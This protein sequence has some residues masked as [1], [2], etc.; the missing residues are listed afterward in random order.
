MDCR[1]IIYNRKS[2]RDFSGTQI[3]DQIITEMIEAARLAP[4]FQNKQCWRFV[5]IKKKEM[6]SRLADHSGLVGKA[7]FF[8][9]KAPLVV[10]A[11]ADPK[12]SGSMNGMDYY[13]VDTSIAFHQMMLLAQSYGIG[14]CWLA[15]FNEKK[16]K[17]VLDI[18]DNIKVVAM[19]PFGYPAEK[20]KLYTK[21]VKIFS[22]SK[23]RLSVSEIACFDNWNL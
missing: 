13:L 5:I 19:S 15:A 11:C 12:R 3:S 14:S 4:S 10:V 9:K 16:V 23:K 8:I 2:L 22:G 6:I 7:N 21:A 20:E 18:P 1:E 17:K